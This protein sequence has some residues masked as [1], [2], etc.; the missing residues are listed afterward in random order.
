MQ[1]VFTDDLAL[2]LEAAQRAAIVL[3][4]LRGD[5]TLQG[6]ALGR[7][8]DRQAN[9]AIVQLLQRERPG[10]GLLSEELAPDASRLQRQ[11]VWIVDPLDGTREYAEPGGRSDWAVHVAL[12]VDAVPRVA[13]VALPARDQSWHTGAPATLPPSPAGAWRIA[14]SRTRAPALAL[15]VADKLGARLLPMGSVGAKVAAVLRGEVHAYL[16]AGGMHEWDSCA[17]VAVARAHG[18]HASRLDGSPCRFNQ[19]EPL[20]PDLLVCR[21]ECAAT[22]LQVAAELAGVG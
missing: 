15:R 7:A 14:V 3:R 17:P 20:T 18:L 10:D 9:A 5:D 1:Q 2:A 13:V 8:G 4:A 12:C 19:A 6:E 16:H 11:R 22:L 21:P